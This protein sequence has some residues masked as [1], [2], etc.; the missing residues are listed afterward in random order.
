MNYYPSDRCTV[1]GCVG[2]QMPELVRV[3]ASRQGLI[4]LFIYYKPCH[5]EMIYLSTYYISNRKETK[6]YHH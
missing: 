3:S 1:L 6:T 4:K 5:F 2:F